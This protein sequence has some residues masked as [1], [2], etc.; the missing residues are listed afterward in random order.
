MPYATDTTVPVERSLCLCVKA[1][2]E[3]VESG[4]SSFESEFL[5]HFVVPGGKTFGEIAIP[6]LEEAR[7]SGK[8]PQLLLG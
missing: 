6:Q 2:L 5:A 1:K 4:I 8:L 7:I 3:A